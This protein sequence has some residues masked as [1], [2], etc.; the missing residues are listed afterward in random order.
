M[1]SPTFALWDVGYPLYTYGSI[2]IITLIIWQVK[3]TYH[4]LRSDTKRNCCQFSI[5]TQVSRELTPPPLSPGHVLPSVD[6]TLPNKSQTLSPAHH[7]LPNGIFLGINQCWLLQEGSVRSVLCTDTSCQ[8]CNA[9]A[10]EVQQLLAGESA[11]VSPTSSGPSRNSSCL[12][13]SSVSSVPFEQNLEHCSAHSQELPLPSPTPPA[14]QFTDQKSLTQPAVQLIDTVN[15]YDDWTE[16]LKLRPGFQVPEVP[17]GPE[18]MSS[19]SLQEPRI[20]VNQQEMTHSDTTPVYRNQEQQPLISQVS[21][22]TPNQGIT[23]LTHSID[24]HMAAALPAQLP[25][26]S[27]EIR[28]RLEVH[29][30]K[31]MHFQR[32]GLPRRVED[33]LRQF[34]PNPPF[35]YEPENN[36]PVAF[37]QNTSKFAV[38]N[39]GTISYQTW[40]SCMT[41]QPTQAFW[42]LEWPIMDPEERHHYQQIP[43]H[44]A[45]TASPSPAL[46]HF[47]GLYPF[48]GQQ[49]NDSVGRLQ[50]KYSQLF[51][52]LPSLHSESLV[53]NFLGSQGFSTNG[54]TSRH[55]LKDPSLLKEL[56]FLPLLPT[57]P[58]QSAPPSSP[59]SPSWVSPCDQQAQVN[60]TFLTLAQCE[61]LEWHLLQ[62]QLQHQRGLPAVFQGSQ[63]TQSSVQCQSC[64]KAQ[65]PERLKT[66][67]PGTPMSVITRGLLFFPEHARRLL[68]LHL[69]RQSIHHRWGLPQKLQESTQLLLSPTDKQTLSWS[70]I[71][72]ANVRVP[73]PTA[74]E[75][76]RAGDPFSSIIDPHSFDQA[77]AILRNHIKS[78]SGQIHQGKV[79]ACVYS[80]WECIIPGSLEVTPLTCTP[81]SKLREL[82]AAAGPDLQ[83]AV[84]PW[85]PTAPEQR[86]A[87]PGGVRAHPKVLRALPTR[88]M[89]K[90]ETALRHKYLAFLSGLPALYSV[91]DS[92]AVA[93]V[94]TTQAVITE[95]GPG[96]DKFP[97]EPLTWR[98]SSDEHHLSSGSGFQDA[99]ETCADVAYEFQPEVEAEG[100][101]EMVPPDSQP[102]PARAYSLKQPL[103]AK[104]TFH[105]RKKILEAQLGIPIK[106]RESREQ[107]AA[108]SENICSWESPGS[109]NNQGKALLQELPIP[110]DIPHAPSPEWLHLK[111]Q[112][113][114]ELKAVKQNEKQPSSR[115]VPQ[116]SAHWASKVSQPSGD[117]AEAQVLCVQLEGS[118]N[119]PSLQEPW[120]PEPQSSGKSKDS[121]QVS[122]LAEMREGPG[123]P[124]SAGDHREGD[125]G[126]VL[127]AAR[128]NRRL[129]EA[130]R[131][132]GMLVNRTPHSPQQQ[133]QGFHPDAPCQ[134]SPQH[135]PQLELPEPPLGVPRGKE[136]KKNG[137]PD[138]QT[139]LSVTRKPAR[140]PENVRPVAPQVSQGQ[141]LL[142]QLVP[143]E[144]LQAQT[145]QGRVLQGQVMPVHNHKSPSLPESGFR[146]KMKSF[147]HHFNP[148]TRSQGH[149]ESKLFIAK[150][151]A[152]TGNENVAKGLAPAKSPTGQTKTET[153]GGELT[154]RR[155]DREG[156]AQS[157]PTEKHQGLAVV[158]GPHPRDSKLQHRSHPL[159]SASVLG[160]PRHCPRHC[161]RVAWAT[162]RGKRP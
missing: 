32:W 109:L 60:V 123:K 29:V 146:S 72:G 129:A 33:S 6:A 54:S 151:V 3:R 122:T 73:Q 25:F 69:L 48:P 57:A 96:P 137:L 36:Q 2:L 156:K 9:V 139:K 15:I 77:K 64:D 19:S 155:Q 101:T 147:L 104:L 7:N 30:E 38:E 74:R 20:L 117:M 59:S 62:R 53:D 43:N 35:F 97:T 126:F 162:Q 135:H 40:G 133:G 66:C 88:A 52:G 42:V 130:Q 4:E 127:S 98:I 51:C 70:S 124:K 128:E 17:W 121:A 55:P 108:A 91:T 50:Q 79:P 49:V 106:A 148:K 82:R 120:S 31:W 68:E 114:T 41:G 158:G 119:S 23:T 93:P 34:I 134:H 16:N 90:L 10:L 28:R 150:K 87:S 115:A 63:H 24:L 153:A 65:S 159:H 116:G 160:H 92:G 110:A 5:S 58:S 157:P 99:S 113:P 18:M 142:G 154:Q 141:P 71:A 112:L 140:T 1:L 81:E 14:S 46:K 136:S 105:M 103:A 83:R 138:S 67:W 161:P 107:R 39:L 78:K 89:E 132:E 143:S 61:A 37:L 100:M 125:A 94:V 85:L 95:T 12:D 118:T 47:S 75:A 144:P 13:I 152:N 86:Q 44:M 149:G 111:E 22:L 11:P 21:L 27:P 102:E 84:M 80:S 76:I 145:V 45:W 131:P 8:T 56:S 26:L